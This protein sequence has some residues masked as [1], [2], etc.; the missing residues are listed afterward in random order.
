[1]EDGKRATSK[2]T[3]EFIGDDFD[4]FHD[5][6]KVHIMQRTGIHRE[7]K[8][9]NMNEKERK[10]VQKQMK[11]I[12]R[13][14]DYV[15]DKRTGME[16]KAMLMEEVNLITILSQSKDGAILKAG[17]EKIRRSRPEKAEIGLKD[18]FSVGGEDI[19]RAPPKGEQM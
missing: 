15:A 10:F 9:S 13:M 18:L 8:L 12:D 6:S 17:L 1:M 4:L 2:D 19:G 14:L 3:T 11:I 5:I 16:I 7:F